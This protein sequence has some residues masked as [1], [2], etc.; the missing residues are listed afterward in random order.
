MLRGL[1]ASI[2]CYDV[3][4][5]GAHRVTRIH[6]SRMRTARSLTV[7]HSH[8]IFLGGGVH[9]THT[10]AIHAPHHAHPPCH[11]CPLGHARPLSVDRITDACENI[12]L[13]QLR[14]GR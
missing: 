10:P 2:E 8:S 6:S 9:V 7:C 12:T 1:G 13:P 11:A 3:L 14:C 5:L 4:A